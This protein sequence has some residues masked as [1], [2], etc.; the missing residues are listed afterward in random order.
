MRVTQSI[1]GGLDISC[2]LDLVLSRRMN[3]RARCGADRLRCVAVVESLAGMTRDLVHFS[4]GRS[5]RRAASALE[6]WA[7][8]AWAGS[9]PVRRQHRRVSCS[10]V[11]LQRNAQDLGV[12]SNHFKTT[13]WLPAHEQAICHIR[14]G[15][16]AKRASPERAIVRHWIS[17]RAGG[18]QSIR[19]RTQEACREPAQ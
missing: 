7:L 1:P 16:S 14:N 17:F 9:A 15:R 5:T 3:L 19:S 4:R 13:P 2:L 12:T 18:S 6:A 10:I 8:E 11:A